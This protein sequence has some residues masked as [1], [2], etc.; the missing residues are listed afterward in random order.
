[1]L[2]LAM[3]LK[4]SECDKEVSENGEIAPE[5]PSEEE[6]DEAAAPVEEEGIFT[7][8]LLI[9]MNIFLCFEDEII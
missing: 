5:E 9:K 1:M 3:Q 6:V 7:K 4:E 8:V 2:K